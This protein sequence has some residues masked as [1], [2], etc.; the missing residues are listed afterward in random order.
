MQ[1]IKNSKIAVALKNG[2]L[3]D[4]KYNE[5]NKIRNNMNKAKP[6]YI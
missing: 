1:K 5:M 2:S 6:T 4:K 3:G